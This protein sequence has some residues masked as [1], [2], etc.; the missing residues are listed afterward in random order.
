MAVVRPFRGVRF[1]PARVGLS[2]VLCPPYDVI[3]SKDARRFRRAS[4]NAIHVEL[5]EGSAASKYRNAARTWK[6][7]RGSARMISYPGVASHGGGS[8]PLSSDVP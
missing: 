4:E 8:K 6:D 5:P 7:W 2:R 1:N 3:S